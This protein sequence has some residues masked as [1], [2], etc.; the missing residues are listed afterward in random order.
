MKLRALGL[1]ETGPSRKNNEDSYLIVPE[2]KL[3]IV[4]DGVG[5]NSSGEVAS[6]TA[7]ETIKEYVSSKLKESNDIKKLLV[8]AIETANTEVIRKSQSNENFKDMATTI[9]MGLTKGKELTVAHAGDSRAYLIRNQQAQQITK[10]HS[11]I[12]ELLEKKLITEEAARTHPKRN[13]IT[14]AIG[15][16]KDIK[17]DVQSIKLK[18]GDFY[19]FCSDGISDPIRESEMGDIILRHGK[20]L[21]ETT[22]EIVSLARKKGS[23]DDATVI[24]INIC[25]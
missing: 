7:T 21:K 18:T 20:N 11:W 1:S 13:V 14:R 6:K 2:L 12:N 17:P 3:F 9:V 25:E 10:D 8:G 15:T 5:G 22:R 19:L 4:A 24:V 16:D 23:T